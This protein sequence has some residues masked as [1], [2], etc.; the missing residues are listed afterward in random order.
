MDAPS[1]IG[2]TT[3]FDQRAAT[4]MGDSLQYYSI[5]LGF[6]IMNPY[7]VKLFHSHL[8]TSYPAKLAIVM[9]LLNIILNYYLTPLLLHR[10]IALAT[11]SVAICYCLLLL[12]TLNYKNYIQI[13]TKNILQWIA[14]LVTSMT[15]FGFCIQFN[16][17]LGL[18][19]QIIIPTLI[20]FSFWHLVELLTSHVVDPLS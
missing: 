8:D 7:I 9:V 10:G 2:F 17:P 13:S 14:R 18:F 20:Y 16:L 6:L 11:S 4:L 1:W 19:G 15:I 12:W 5:G 3:Q